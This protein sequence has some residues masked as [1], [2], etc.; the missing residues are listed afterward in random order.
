MAAVRA[1]S[2]YTVLEWGLRLQSPSL[3][4]AVVSLVSRLGTG[5]PS[6]SDWESRVS[7]ANL[8]A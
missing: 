4:M 2:W 1:M 6:D 3:V 5:L 8:A 7:F